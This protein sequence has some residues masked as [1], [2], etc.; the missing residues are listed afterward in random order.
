MAS[1]KLFP[2]II[3]LLNL[4]VTLSVSTRWEINYISFASFKFNALNVI[5]DAVNVI[6]L[7]RRKVNQIDP[8]QNIE[9]KNVL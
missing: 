6:Y 4:K 1:L 2:T 7:L 9:D 3:N 8:Q 5:R